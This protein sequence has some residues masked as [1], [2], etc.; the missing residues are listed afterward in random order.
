[1]K[2]VLIANSHEGEAAEIQKYLKRYFQLT[3]IST[4]SEWD[5]R[6]TRFDL[7]LVD[8]NFTANS[9]ID[10][11]MDILRSQTLPILMLTP[12]SDPQCA[13]EALRVGAF[14]YIIKTGGFL[15]FLNIAIVDALNKFQ[16]RQQLKETI[17][18][19]REKLGELGGK[20][21]AGHVTGTPVSAPAIGRRP[22]RPGSPAQA[23]APPQ[24]ELN[25]MEEIISRFKKGDVNLPTLPEINLKFNN[26][27]KKGANLKEVADFL[28]QDVAITSKLINVSNSA[29]YKGIEKTTRLE[30]AISK[31]GLGK[32]RQYV[33]IIANRSLYTSKNKRFSSLVE[34]LWEH[35]LAT[36]YASEF[37]LDLLH[38]KTQNDIFALGLTHDIGK[39]ILLQVIGELEVKGKYLAKIDQGKILATLKTY[40]GKFGAVLLNRWGFPQ[41]F[42]DVAMYHDHFHKV[43]DP[44]PEFLCVHFANLLATDLGYNI[45]TVKGI[46]LENTDSG[47]LLRLR[48]DDI[49]LTRE[50]TTGYID[51][52]RQ[53]L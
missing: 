31:L 49:E 34:K 10:F 51:S 3:V 22:V 26:L 36:A 35:S 42:K 52:I 19:L 4:P 15:K 28:K 44:T 25:L 29:L 53:A 39:L 8:H 2:Q 38:L 9:G 17:S 50:K 46:D 5:S 18:G 47:Y 11:L 41:E 45:E 30:D 7:V 13:I 27:V 16:E 48:P 12:S 40:H 1:M 43:K 20:N 14:N 23:P 24:K 33:E 37:V 32:T 6:D 21:R